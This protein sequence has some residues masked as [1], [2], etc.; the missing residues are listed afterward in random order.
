MYLSYIRCLKK[1]LAHKALIYVINPLSSPYSSF[2]FIF[3]K[4]LI[5]QNQKKKVRKRIKVKGN[6][7]CKCKQ[8]CCKNQLLG[9]EKHSVWP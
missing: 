6:H 7:V 4:D 3:L 2:L 5:T 9:R 8:R 1:R